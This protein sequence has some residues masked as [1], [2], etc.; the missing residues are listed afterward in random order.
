MREDKLGVFGVAALKELNVFELSVQLIMGVNGSRFSR[1]KDIQAIVIEFASRVKFTNVQ[2]GPYVG[3]VGWQ[4][5]LQ[6]L[7]VLQA[8]DWPLHWT[9]VFYSNLIPGWETEKAVGELV[10]AGT[11]LRT[12]IAQAVDRCVHASDA[13]YAAKL[14]MLLAVCIAKDRLVDPFGEMDSVF[15][16]VDQMCPRR[17]KANVRLLHIVLGQLDRPNWADRVRE[18]AGRCCADVIKQWIVIK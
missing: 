8:A 5:L 1:N 16:G 11:R 2:T 14:T 12:T 6:H 10:D 3:E 4:R 7:W 17:L 15:R 9:R 13:K 18:M